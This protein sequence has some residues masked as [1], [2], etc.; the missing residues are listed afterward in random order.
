MAKSIRL[1]IHTHCSR[2]LINRET[3]VQGSEVV[4]LNA[5]WLMDR[6]KE[7]VQY[8]GRRLRD[9][10]GECAGGTGAAGQRK[11]KG[12]VRRKGETRKEA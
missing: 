7:H 10:Q 2:H 8:E 6:D 11:E 9:P 3:E 4:C 12:E 5:C 1:L